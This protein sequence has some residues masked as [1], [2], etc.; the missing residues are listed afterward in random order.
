MDFNNELRD[1]ERGRM[2]AA[3]D[4]RHPR[5]RALGVPSARVKIIATR[6]K[7]NPRFLNEKAKTQSDII[8]FWIRNEEIR[9]ILGVRGTGS[10]FQTPMA[11][12][13][14]PNMTTTGH[15]IGQSN[16]F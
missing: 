10:P 11:P 15:K 5:G 12:S 1:V 4:G 8:Y 14:N 3:C 7:K 13:L 2:L 16:T 9:T 6:R